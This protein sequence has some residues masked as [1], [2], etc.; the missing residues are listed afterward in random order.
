MRGYSPLMI[1]W[2]PGR[3]TPR[4]LVPPVWLGAAYRPGPSPR[5]TPGPLFSQR[6][7][8]ALLLKL[9]LATN[10]SRHRAKSAPL[11]IRRRRFLIRRRFLDAAAA[12]RKL[13]RAGR[14][15]R[16]QHKAKQ[17]P[18]LF[19]PKSMCRNLKQERP[20]RSHLPD[21]VHRE[22]YFDGAFGKRK[23]KLRILSRGCK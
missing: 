18:K 23:W 5:S 6:S 7:V 22:Q 2:P 12:G 8:S 1:G 9:K 10:P 3:P 17:L 4:P 14:H 16:S 15:K 21:L 11:F 19:N 13:E 20:V